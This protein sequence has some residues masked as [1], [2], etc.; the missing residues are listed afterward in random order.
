MAVSTDVAYGPL[1]H[2][3][4]DF[5]SFRPR[6]KISQIVISIGGP[7]NNKNNPIG[8]TF[9][10]TNND[11]SKDTLS[12]GGGGSDTA[13]VRKETIDI[14]GTDEYLTEISGTF[15][16]LDRSYN[17]LRSIKFTTNAREF[18]TYGPNVGTP[19]NFQA[20]NDNKIV[21]FFGRAGFY[22]DAIGTYNAP[23]Y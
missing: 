11:G 16:P 10:T 19:F 5:W 17:V 21:G 12:I 2:N 18:G 4:G 8:L 7:G 13:V 9:S 22:I 1:G 23:D 6:N 3:G 20:Q 14:D 15:G